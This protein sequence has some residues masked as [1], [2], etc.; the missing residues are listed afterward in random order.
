VAEDLATLVAGARALGIALGP[1]QQARF[2]AYSELLLEWNERIN[3]LGP[4]AVLALWSRHLL[5]ALTII[6]ALPVALAD[7]TMA[8][9][10]LDVGSGA[11]LPGIPLQIAFPAW[12]VT[13]LEA[14]GKRATF[15]ELAA[16]ELGLSNLQVLQG[17]AED[18]ARDG[19]YREA[20]DLCVARAVTNAA[21]LVELTLPF[22][23]IGGSVILYKSLAGLGDELQA[24][25]T[26]RVLLGAAAP[27]V[28]P[29]SGDLDGRCLVRYQKLGRTP[30]QLPRSTGVPER[31]PLTQADAVR[32]AAEQAMAKERRAARKAQRPRRRRR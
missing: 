7:T 3:L 21:G 28:V 8:Q 2:V 9:A 22:V 25:E 23:A 14:T 18:L 1:E 16:A 19:D 5:D 17:R 20:F 11:G 10:V 15:L 24:A 6:A 13:L 26:A 27:S 31:H 12:Q 4:A 29:L 32:I 30:S